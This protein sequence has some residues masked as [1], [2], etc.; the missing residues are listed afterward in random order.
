MARHTQVLVILAGEPDGLLFP[1]FSVVSCSCEHHIHMGVI[2]ILVVNG[3]PMQFLVLCLFK[4][5]HHIQCPLT[6]IQDLLVLCWREH[7]FVIAHTSTAMFHNIIHR[8]LAMYT[9]SILVK[10]AAVLTQFA[11]QVQG[12]MLD[13]LEMRGQMGR[14]SFA[15]SPT[16][17]ASFRNHRLSSPS[18]LISCDDALV[19]TFST[20]RLPPSSFAPPS[21]R[22]PKPV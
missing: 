13:I 15:I 6:P 18:I 9:I 1:C 22:L 19:V 16:H 20:P 8:F 3:V 2:R 7:D 4:I 10:Q 17:I 12:S 21:A 5:R 14:R 11:Y